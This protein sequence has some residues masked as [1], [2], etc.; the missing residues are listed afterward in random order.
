MRA[1][2]GLSADDL[3]AVFVGGDWPRKGL[4]HAIAAVARTERWKLLVVG[5]GHQASYE[6]RARELGVDAR[7]R[8]AG[9]TTDVP[10]HLAAGDVFCLPTQY[11]AFCLVAFEA[12]AAGLP[13]LVTNVS[14]PDMLIE[15]EVNGEFLDADVKRTARLLDGYVDPGRR[16]AHGKAAR[17]R[18]ITFTWDRATDAHLA[19]YARL[20]GETTGRGDR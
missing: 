2:H 20:A 6:Q 1:R 9:E 10:A 4:E 14:G 5:R 12:A 18:A 16:R 13:V 19:L 3:V 7:V 11:E 8:F 15:S 17:A